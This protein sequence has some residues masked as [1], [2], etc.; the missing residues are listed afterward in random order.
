MSL[1]RNGTPANGPRS[2]LDGD[3]GMSRTI[4]LIRGFTAAA[5]ACARA[6]SS[7][8]DAS[9]SATSF[10]RPVASYA[11]YSSKFIAQP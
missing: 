2:S 9:L 4:A 7:V 10:A 5:R 1:I 11:R 6:S 8:A 3:A